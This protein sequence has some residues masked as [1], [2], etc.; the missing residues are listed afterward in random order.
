LPQKSVTKNTQ[1]ITL[2]KVQKKIH[3]VRKIFKK[4]AIVIRVLRS[5]TGPGKQGSE[6]KNLKDYF[7]AFEGRQN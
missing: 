2:K 6:L 3:K 5:P 1:K 4:G 7:S